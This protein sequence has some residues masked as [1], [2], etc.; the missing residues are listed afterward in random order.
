[1]NDGERVFIFNDKSI[2][3]SLIND[4]YTFLS[5]S[6]QNFVITNLDRI[7]S[8]QTSNM[9]FAYSQN[10]SS[11]YAFCESSVVNQSLA[12]CVNGISCQLANCGMCNFGSSNCLSCG[13]GYEIVNGSCSMINNQQ[14]STNQTAPTNGSNFSNNQTV[15]GNQTV[16][17]NQTDSANQTTL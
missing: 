17:D 1:M 16:S 15:S 6:Q 3:V 14:N 7:V 9:S 5:Y 2:K 11:V 12:G 4:T 10:S 8:F 13:S